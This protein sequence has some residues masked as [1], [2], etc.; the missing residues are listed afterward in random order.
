MDFFEYVVPPLE[1]FWWQDGMN[2]T[3]D[4]NNKGEMHFISII[5]LSDFVTKTDFDWAIE[6]A[7]KKKNKI[8]QELN[9][10]LMMRVFAYNVC[11]LEVMM[12]SQQQLN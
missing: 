4:Y 2:G 5:R 12:M 3:I 10:L 9:F 8:F 1:G 6:E 7:T 11:T